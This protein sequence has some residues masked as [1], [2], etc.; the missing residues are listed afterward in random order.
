MPRNP[1]VVIVGAGPYGLSIAAHLRFHGITFRIVGA[2]LSLW[3]NHMPEGMFLKSDGFASNLSDPQSHFTLKRYCHEAGVP[4]HDVHIPVRLDT[5]VEYGD[6]FQKVNVPTLENA[7][8]SAIT[9][10]PAGFRV[11]LGTGEQIQTARVVVATGISHFSYTP[12]ELER[13]A[14]ERVSHSFAH[15]S[16]ERFRAKD[17]VVV[18]GGASA[19]DVAALLHER[20]ARVRV[21][22]RAETVRFNEPRSAGRRSVVQRLRHPDSGVGPSLQGWFYSNYPHVFYHFPREVRLK[23]V[24]RFLGPAAGWTVK[25]RVL[26]RIPIV[27]G[28]R[29]TQATERNGCLYL[30][31]SRG[32]NDVEEIGTEHVIAA[33][34]YRVNLKCLRFLSE[35]IRSRLITCVDSPVLSPNFQSSVSGLYFVGLTAANSFGPALR[36][37]FGAEFAARTM[38]RHFV[39]V[40]NGRAIPAVAL[41]ENPVV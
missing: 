39:K 12:P 8:V 18:G 25:D 15:G 34:G 3:R 31:L 7:E 24:T 30:R 36:F 1:D 41:K 5:F 20:G 22:T 28:A 33:T 19:M 37:A 16:V 6:A 32:N 23:I 14:T 10:E 40:L 2:P 11:Q 9:Q 4:Y 13:L 26:G 35:S 27:T 29:I 21:I 38:T 17:V